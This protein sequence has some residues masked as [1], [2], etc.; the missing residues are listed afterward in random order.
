MLPL[1]LGSHPLATKTLRPRTTEQPG[2][3][4]T[5]PVYA[6]RTVLHLVD[7]IENILGSAIWKVI[8]T[9]VLPSMT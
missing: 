1:T 5:V 6:V 7:D 8:A 2:N 4:P 3:I 9:L